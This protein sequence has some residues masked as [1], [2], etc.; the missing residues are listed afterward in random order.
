M[1][2]DRVIEKTERARL[3]DSRQKDKEQ[4][5]AL[6]HTMKSV[7]AAQ[8]FVLSPRVVSAC[9][10]VC[11]WKSIRKSRD[12]LFTPAYNTWVEWTDAA[13][14]RVAVQFD[15]S[16]MDNPTNVLGALLVYAVIRWGGQESFSFNDGQFDFPGDR[17]IFTM[18]PWD[19][20]VTHV[21]PEQLRHVTNETKT[22]YMDALKSLTEHWDRIARVAIG[23]LALINTPHVSIQVPADL[24]KLN[25]SREKRRQPAILSYTDVDI[26]LDGLQFKMSPKSD[27]TGMMPFHHVRAHMRLVRGLMTMVRPHWRGNP[28]N[29][30]RI[31][32]HN[33]ITGDD[34]HGPWQGGVMPGP[35]I[36]KE[37]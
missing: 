19:D 16:A 5:A 6:E 8:R 25:R 3:N 12:Y 28:E 34:R 18:R 24:A 26:R 1:F 33:V 7:R 30:V 10:E 22:E 9:E 37:F 21:M 4:L 20:V 13:V 35:S 11:D 15:S 27:R 2:A 36:I 14:G 23:A 31:A 29:G 32:R 17:S